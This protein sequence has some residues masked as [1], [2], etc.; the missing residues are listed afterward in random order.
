M[1][2]NKYWHPET[3]AFR[4]MGAPLPVANVHGTDEQIR[5]RLKPMKVDKWELQGNTLI[6]YA[7]G[8]KMA[9]QIPTDMILLGTDENNLPIL[10]KIDL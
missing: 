3:D 2:V 7:D 10:Q 9:Q 4:K 8:V 5:E 6:G 1:P